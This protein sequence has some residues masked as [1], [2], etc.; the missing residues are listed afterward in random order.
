[1]PCKISTHTYCILQLHSKIYMLLLI[2]YSLKVYAYTHL[3]AFY[4]FATLSINP[5]DEKF[6][7]ENSLQHKLRMNVAVGVAC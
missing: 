4:S 6:I 7:K 3:A 5:H 2:I 1:M